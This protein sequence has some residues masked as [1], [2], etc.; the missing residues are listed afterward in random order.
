MQ[1]IKENIRVLDKKLC[2]NDIHSAKTLSGY[3][4]KKRISL[5]IA[6]TIYYRFLGFW[7]KEYCLEQR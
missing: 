1:F 2:Q 4:W 7:E 6:L 5:L 3:G